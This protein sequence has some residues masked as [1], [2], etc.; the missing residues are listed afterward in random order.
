MKQKPLR[1]VS[2]TF[3]S[4]SIGWLEHYLCITQIGRPFHSLYL[5]GLQENSAESTGHY[6][7]AI[8]SLYLLRARG[9]V[10]IVLIGWTHQV[11]C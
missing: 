7:I 10:L 8:G 2:V 6:T 1:A 9:I 5:I 4:F 3:A 11:F